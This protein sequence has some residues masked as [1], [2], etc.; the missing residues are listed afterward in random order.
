MRSPFNRGAQTRAAIAALFLSLIAF[1]AVLPHAHAEGLHIDHHVGAHYHAGHRHHRHAW[2]ARR[3]QRA[4]VAIDM[5]TGAID[6]VQQNPFSLVASLFQ[7][8]VAAAQ[9]QIENDIAAAGQVPQ[10]VAAAASRSAASVYAMAARLAPQYRVPVPIAISEVTQESHGNCHARSYTDARGALQV[11]PYTAVR[12]GYD[13]HRLFEC[14][15]GLR[16]GLAELQRLIEEQGEITCHTI[17][18]Y[19]GSPH[20]VDRHGGCTPYGRQVLARAR[21]IEAHPLDPEIWE[22]SWT[23]SHHHHRHHWRV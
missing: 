15:Y 1:F 7:P 3:H 20:Y 14:E 12:D 22:A 10:R 23:G 6:P 13:P 4:L 9:S 17:S 2:L 8:P 5:R 19:E 21:A 11:E 16:A 18:L